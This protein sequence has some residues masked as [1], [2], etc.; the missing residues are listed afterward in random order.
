MGANFCCRN[1]RD[2]SIPVTLAAVPAVMPR[3]DKN[4]IMN[5]IADSYRAH[6]KEKHHKKYRKPRK[7]I[8][9]IRKLLVSFLVDGTTRVSND[10]RATSRL[11]GERLV[12]MERV[13]QILRNRRNDTAPR[14]DETCKARRAALSASSG[15]EVV[16]VGAFVQQGILQLVEEHVF[17]C[18]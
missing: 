13:Q 16:R 17:G 2:D 6:P 5:S 4:A 9:K 14:G 15:D 3:G 11:Q 18:D 12:A 1:Q 10:F 8:K 7:N